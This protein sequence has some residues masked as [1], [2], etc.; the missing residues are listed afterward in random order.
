MKLSWF[1][2]SRKAQALLLLLVCVA[3]VAIGYRYAKKHRATMAAY[4]HAMPVQLQ[5]WKS[6][7]TAWLPE[8]NLSIPPGTTDVFSLF[9]SVGHQHKNGL[10]E[11]YG[12][13]LRHR[14]AG[15]IRVGFT[16]LHVTH[17]QSHVSWM[18]D[19]SPA[20]GASHILIQFEGDVPKNGTLA[21]YLQTRNGGK[22]LFGKR[23]G[24]P[25][26][27]LQSKALP[28]LIPDELAQWQ[29]MS[30]TGTLNKSGGDTLVAE[31]P[32]QLLA[33]LSSASD[34]QIIVRLGLIVD[35]TGQDIVKVKRLALV[36]FS[37]T[38]KP[39]LVSIGGKLRETAFM[40]GA[41][42]QLLMENGV[43]REQQL[44]VD[45]GFNFD[46]IPIGSVISLRFHHNGRFYYSSLGRWVA[47]SS[48]R[49]NVDVSTKP[50]FQN[51]EGRAPDP[52]K[53]KFITPRQPSTVA[54][55]YESHA[56][57]AWPG[58]GTLQEFDSITFTNNYGFIDRDRFFDNPD[59]CMRYVHLGSS[60]AVALQVR[61][62]EKYNI[63]LESE[64]SIR[65]Q[66]CV[67]VISA[68]RDNGDIG[69]NYP[70][71]RDYALHFKPDA[72][73]LENSS[74]L[75]MQLHPKLLRLGFGWNHDFNA[76][77]HFSYS[78]QGEIEFREW[79]SEYALHASKP[80]YTPLQSGVPLMRTL[81][82]PF[83]YMHPDGKEAFKYLVDILNYF[84]K[85]HKDQRFILHTGLDEAQCVGRCMTAVVVPG[86][87]RVQT[88]AKAF[89]E[90]HTMICGKAGLE[91]I[92]PAY[93]VDHETKDTQLTFLHDGHYRI[94]G[95]QWLARELA[96]GLTK[97]S[98][99]P[100]SGK[101]QSGTGVEQ[102]G[103][104]HSIQY[105]AT[106]QQ[107]LQQGLI[108]KLPYPF[109]HLVTI[110]SDV[111]MQTPE[112][113]AAIHRLI[114]EQ[115]GLPIADSIWVQG[116]G[117]NSTSLF[118]GGIDL[119]RTPVGD[120]HETWGFLVREWHRGNADSFHSW[121]DDGVPRLLHVTSPPLQLATSSTTLELQDAPAALRGYYYRNLRLQFSGACPD[122]LTLHLHD[123]AGRQF[124]VSSNDIRRG[125][126]TMISE[127]PN[128]C[129]TNLVFGVPGN[130]GIPCDKSC[131]DLTRL[132]KIVLVA[133]S[134]T[135]SCKTHLVN[136]SRDNFSRMTVAMQLPFVNALN[137]RPGFLSSHGGWTFAQNFGWDDDVQTIP[138][139]HGSMY[140]HT[141]VDNK[142]IPHAA[143]PSS[144]AFHSDL[145]KELG[146]TSVWSYFLSRKNNARRIM[147]SHWKQALNS[148]THTFPGFY[149]VQRTAVTEEYSL[150]TV[151]KF[152]N[153]L[154]K[155][156][157][158]LKTE[159]LQKLYCRNHCGGD[160]GAVLGLLLRLSM[161][162]IE[163]G[164]ETEHIW[165]THLGSGNPE[166]KRTEKEPLT[167][168]A[169]SQLQE[170][171]KYYFGLTQNLDRKRIWVPPAGV[172]I[173]Y[174]NMRQAVSRH[175]RLNPSTS[176]V[177]VS[178]W[179]D[180]VTGRQMAAG[181]DALRY[182]QGLTIYV[183]NASIARIFVNGKE[184]T[185]FTRNS[186]D[187][188]GKQ[189]VTLVDDTTPQLLFHR[190][191]AK[192]AGELVAINGSVQDFSPDKQGADF[193]RA[194]NN[195]G[196]AIAEWRPKQLRIINATH[197]AITFRKNAS[198][199]GRLFFELEMA[200]GGKIVAAEPQIANRFPGV[201]HWE[202]RTPDADSEKWTTVVLPITSLIWPEG[203]QQAK[204]LPIGV[205]KSVKFGILGAQGV[206]RLEVKYLAG[207]RPNSNASQPDGTRMIGGQLIGEG[208]K[209]LRNEI[210]R[211][212]L[213]GGKSIETIS[214]SG[215][216]YFFY[217]LPMNAVVSIDSGKRKC[218][219][220][221]GKK[222]VIAK[223][224]PEWDIDFRNCNG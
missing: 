45:G 174:R 214:D 124:V 28:P 74:S 56:R 41:R 57:Q 26:K 81:Q 24:Q 221:R 77:D 158:E 97:Q 72:V 12:A 172:A 16:E 93:P 4:Y 82:V 115:L 109:T 129:I 137:L 202:I 29:G 223:D 61:P 20:A 27:K 84:K 2:R 143:N 10:V 22:F 18:P 11:I 35:R 87:V 140:E 186:P 86:G 58:L 60:H 75:V 224:D 196:D 205:V 203:A 159:F 180:P 134:C 118:S 150:D 166:F 88:G 208:G 148:P 46:S 187:H 181:I 54:A 215:G 36:K 189:S 136:V 175:V 104:Q 64:L 204:P 89:T 213:E 67:E 78:G 19:Y 59:G 31:L 122:D 40:P 165:Y 42:M 218:S 168:T 65:H 201:P 21:V 14:Q 125:R 100:G 80:D 194:S 126:Q 38:P 152:T 33:E 151:E 105:R 96:D 79:S 167:G 188:S 135:S 178:P 154:R 68:G 121:Q 219:A 55:I 52:S 210:V 209:P 62:F 182:L 32:Q 101:P 222:T 220:D 112:H 39:E 183:P 173:N 106:E 30:P 184:T 3:S 128:A 107:Q 147:Q 111:D 146:V 139:T 53:A 141:A 133:P 191:P 73:L 63:E 123:D 179:I 176:E 1:P 103:Q 34:D 76:L 164:E 200:D 8:K 206:A 114:N 153:E 23:L 212:T 108:R 170:L 98:H 92:H 199:G 102:I 95:H 217:R 120:N 149:D 99:S 110:A 25:A 195:A 142:L 198:K 70:R 163:R 193:I 91:C 85:A 157:P 17:D 15:P 66:K 132:R 207:L 117:Q 119:N 71:I 160:Q 47:A 7:L 131:F 144:F 6:A 211:L 49:S 113:G 138:R 13:N 216:Y 197:F 94:Q 9:D 130:I 43:S 44:S 116:S 161:L 127:Q 37:D 192:E 155:L 48:N 145:L 177:Y 5:H 51:P 162:R 156:E 190:L 69:S 83:A 50:L 171:A 90:N 169:I 185:S